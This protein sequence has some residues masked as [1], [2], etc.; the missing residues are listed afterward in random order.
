M[1]PDVNTIQVDMP[2]TIAAY[3]VSNSD[4]SYTIVLNARMSF[5]RKR[6]AYLHEIG[7]INNGDY[8]KNCADSI[9]IYAHKLI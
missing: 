4:C 3:V 5:E 8:E 9:E 6:E 1:I 2:T 7:H